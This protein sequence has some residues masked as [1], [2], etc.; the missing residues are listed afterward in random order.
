MKQN[1]SKFSSNRTNPAPVEDPVLP[2][3]EEIPENELEPVDAVMAEDDP[4]EAE[5]PEPEKTAPPMK[6]TG[7]VNCALLNVRK[8]P[9][10]MAEVVAKI[11]EG[12]QVTLEANSTV[13][14]YAVTLKSGVTGYCMK[15]F[16]TVK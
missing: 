5:Q 9:N 8:S 10:K 6:L 4:V 14:W 15:K 3:A 13:E 16:I 7:V 1:Y 12:E 11:P 2:G